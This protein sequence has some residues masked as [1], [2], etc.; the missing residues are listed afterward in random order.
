MNIQTKAG[1]GHNDPPPFDPAAI[2]GFGPR[3]QDFADAAGAWLDAGEIVSAEQA[4]KLNDYIAGCRA[5]YRKIEGQRT[6][7]KKPHL[8]A[9]KLVDA[10]YKKLTAPLTKA[11]DRVK[12]LLTRWAVKQAEIEAE[13]KRKAEAAAAAE[14]EAASKF[15][16]QAAARNDVV[17]EAEAEQ[18]QKDADKAVKQAARASTTGRVASAT[19]GGRTSALRTYHTPK[20]TSRRMAFLALENDHGAALDEVILRIAA[21]VKRA[22]ASAEI[23]GIEFTEQKRIA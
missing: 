7:D 16:E 6:A 19:G 4:E 8:D 10:T 18:A 15:A 22:D 2:K 12:P 1:I 5:L 9:G 11:A 13:N 17:G 20:I 14:Q 21:Q 23:Q 3:V